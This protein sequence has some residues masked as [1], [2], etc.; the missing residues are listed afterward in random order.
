MITAVLATF[1]VVFSYI[2]QPYAP[3]AVLFAWIITL[4]ALALEI[5]KN[6][7]K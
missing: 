4:G 2:L 1:F 7:H 5:I 6:N 3:E